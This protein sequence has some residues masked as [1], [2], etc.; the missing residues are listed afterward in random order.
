MVPTKR[1]REARRT[2]GAFCIEL[3]IYGLLVTAYFFGVLLF[4]GDRLVQLEM[5]HLRV[6]AA[7]AILLMIGQAVLL[8][9]ITTALLRLLRGGRSE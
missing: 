8:E 4:L 6:Y 5:H 1:E 2:L 3:V 9:A 7:L